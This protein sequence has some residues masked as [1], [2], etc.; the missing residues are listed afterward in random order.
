VVIGK[1]SGNSFGGFP[2]FRKTRSLAS[3][4]LVVDA[5]LAPGKSGP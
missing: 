5:I 2:I 4:A 3:F 1:P